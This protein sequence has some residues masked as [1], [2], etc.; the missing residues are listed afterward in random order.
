MA[1]FFVPKKNLRDNRGLIEGQEL[2]HL[3]KVLRLVPG[4]SITVFDDSD[5]EHEAV[6]RRLSAEQGEIEIIRSYQ[7]DRES[8]LQITLGIGLTKG[9]KM[10]FVVEKATELGVQTIAPF[11]STFS[12]PKLD[13]RKITA[14]TARWEKIALSA[15]KQ[16][17]RTR[18]PEIL[19]LCEFERWI[20]HDRGET[21]KLLF[22]ENEQRQ[23]VHEAREKYPEEK[24]VLLA[25]GPEGGFAAQEAEAAKSNGFEP[26]RI[27]RRILRAETAAVA[28]LSLV[29]F[30]WGDLR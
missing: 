27:G 6:I 3:K 30:L 20:K 2:A 13:A 21:L 4:D 25:I 15:S 29:Q 12:V 23:S 26:I 22:W 18:V 28:A 24:S 8:P 7:A 14:R 19:P 9:E 17:G 16:C 5:W 11:I 10:D 1:R